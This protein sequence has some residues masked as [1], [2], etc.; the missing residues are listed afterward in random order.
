MPTVCF[1]DEYYT[2]PAGSH[3]SD[4]PAY[5]ASF[6]LPCGGHG[7]CGKCRVKAEGQL[8]PLS[9]TELLK[10]TPDEIAG[11]M[12]LACSAV[13]LGD[14][15]VR[16]SDE[17][18]STVRL[19]GAMPAFAL[20]PAFSRYGAA[21][22]IGTTTLA[23]RLY[24]SDGR[25][26][27]E[28]GDLNPQ[29][30]FGA[31]V[32][33]RME[34]ALRGEAHDL[35][36]LVREAVCELLCRLSAAAQIEPSDIDGLVIT[37]NTAMLHLLT[38]TDVEPLTH[39]PFE[40][41]RLF[42]EEITAS[43]LDLDVLA[44]DVPVY[45]PPCAA[46]FVGADLITAML[47]AGI[48]DIPKT[49]VLVDIGTNGEMVL[50]HGGRMFFCSTA[51][52][53][54]FEGAGISMGMGGKTGAV[55]RVYLNEG[56]LCAHVIGDDAPPVGICGS[57]VIDAVACLL[58][59]GQLDDTGYLE[60][61]PAV[62]EPPVTLTQSD[63]RAVQLAKSAI[64]AGIRT[65]LHSAGLGL[66]DVKRLIIAGGFGSYLDVE[67]AGKIGL[68]PTELVPVVQV[69]GNAALSGAAMLLLNRSFRRSCRDF[70]GG[71]VVDLS[72]NPVFADE[73]ME[74]MLFD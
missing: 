2:L 45:L 57:G 33:S 69:V 17:G 43:E 36:R 28:E 72:A 15:T 65:L 51:A 58:E 35:A 25:L 1:N 49:A 16:V 70:T 55:D 50:S 38:E 37:G 71:T 68:L 30:G 62:I 20:E 13:V 41:S 27:A 42:D 18:A 40:A 46:A 14:C 19:S 31:D 52:G 74:R 73:Y 9:Q 29:S 48:S 67:N 24:A 56:S 8:S 23:A 66:S 26:L 44:P 10:L 64:H 3:I 47:A 7:K 53:P 63:V 21:L 32:I 11:G 54:A 4:L 61:E 39:A 5:R 6:G 22:D 12:R 34:A 59:T 60:D